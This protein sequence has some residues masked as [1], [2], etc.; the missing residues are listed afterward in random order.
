VSATD[1][2]GITANLRANVSISL[3]DA[4]QHP[5]EFTFS[6]YRFSVE[7][8][9]S[10]LTLVGVIEATGLNVIYTILSGDPNGLV[11]CHTL[12]DRY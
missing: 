1:G 6:L 2:G 3:R 7:E 9:A 12:G 4:S 10:I 11:H 5:P 8:D